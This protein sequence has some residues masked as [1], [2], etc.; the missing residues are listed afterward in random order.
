MWIA[1]AVLVI[2][3]VAACDKTEGEGPDDG[4]GDT[5]K[6]LNVVYDGD[7]KQVEIGLTGSWHAE[8]DQPWC[9]LVTSEGSGVAKVDLNIAY[10]Y[11]GG[12]RTANITV[13]EGSAKAV[14]G[15]TRAGGGYTIEVKQAPNTLSDIP[16]AFTEAKFEGQKVYYKMW[17]GPGGTISDVAESSMKYYSGGGMQIADRATAKFLSATWTNFYKFNIT[18]D[19]IIGWLK[20]GDLPTANKIVLDQRETIRKYENSP[21]LGTGQVNFVLGDKLY[22]GG[23]FTSGEGQMSPLGIGGSSSFVECFTFY[24]FDPATGT[25]TKLKDL[26]FSRGYGTVMDGKA[27]A[28]FSD[29]NIYRYEVAS[30]SWTQMGQVYPSYYPPAFYAFGGKFYVY[31]GAKR[32]EYTLGT[33]GT[34]TAGPAITVSA[35]AFKVCDDGKGHVWLVDGSTAYAHTAT[36][37]DAINCA[38]TVL[39]AYDGSLYGYTTDNDNTIYK[40][41]A[42]GSQDSVFPGLLVIPAC[43]GSNFGPGYISYFP[44]KYTA[45]V[46]N[47]LVLFG[48]YGSGYKGT[49]YNRGYNSSL[50]MYSLSLAN[51]KEP[52]LLLV[53]DK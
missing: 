13:S 34:L 43:G 47:K 29:L 30:D 51:P 53:T 15:G 10:N 25:Q 4:G 40:L 20:I 7:Q 12:E 3:S 28:L 50:T 8:S 49:V 1:A 26:P 38:S 16:P 44:N 24:S 42:D 18:S 2:A 17:T 6:S 22:Y 21:M 35:S 27:Y 48:G 36:G 5:P 41:K 33:D 52:K 9:Q 46:N 32:Y 39:G 14:S 11:T 37:Y 23:G 19:E 45:I 31:D